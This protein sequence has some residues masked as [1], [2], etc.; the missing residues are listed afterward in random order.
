[1]DKLFLPDDFE[2]KYRGPRP[3]EL[4]GLLHMTEGLA[5]L[6]GIHL[7]HRNIK[8]HHILISLSNNNVPVMKLAD[9]GLAEKVSPESGS[10]FVKEV[11]CTKDWPAPEILKLIHEQSIQNKGSG[12]DLVEGTIK[13]DVFSAGLVFFYW[14]TEGIHPFG[15]SF[16]IM[17]NIFHNRPVNLEREL[18][19][20]ISIRHQHF[21]KY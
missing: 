9:F 11:R 14:L 8:P 7:T 5:Y 12:I 15:E 16:L 3:S 18:A 2:E 1:M 20:Y 10:Y 19:H 6:H 4:D 17:V 13:S 21:K